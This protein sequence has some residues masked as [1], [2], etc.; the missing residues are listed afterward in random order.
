MLIWTDLARGDREMA[1]VLVALNAVFQV[2]LYSMLG[3]FYLHVP[4]AAIAG[5]VWGSRTRLPVLTWPSM[6]PARTR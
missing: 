5:T 1:T 3:F 4:M 6:Q 2:L